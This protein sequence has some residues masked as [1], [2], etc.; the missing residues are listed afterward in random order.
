M[1]TRRR[2]SAR[3]IVGRLGFYHFDVFDVVALEGEAGEVSRVGLDQTLSDGVEFGHGDQL[4]ISACP[5]VQTHR[6]YLNNASITCRK[7][8]IRSPR[9]SKGRH[10]PGKRD[11]IR[12]PKG[13]EGGELDA[14]K[15]TEGAAVLLAAATR[16]EWPSGGLAR[17]GL[18][19]CGRSD[20]WS[21]GFAR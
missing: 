1:R 12:V 6:R 10:Y 15:P 11:K 14:D 5:A 21:A 13:D 18:A 19:R 8:S 9:R 17:L 20:R 3:R 4:G 16:S 2:L 7:L